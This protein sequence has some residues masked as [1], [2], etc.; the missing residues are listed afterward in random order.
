MLE[1]MEEPVVLEADNRLITISLRAAGSE[2]EKHWG[3]WE[4]RRGKVK[5]G[6]PGRGEVSCTRAGQER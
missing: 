5:G 2:M 3:L 1:H 6:P 4:P